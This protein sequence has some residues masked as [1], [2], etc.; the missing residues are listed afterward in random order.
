[1][2]MDAIVA[3]VS[4]ISEDAYFSLP[5]LAAVDEIENFLPAPKFSQNQSQVSEPME[6]TPKLEAKFNRLAQSKALNELSLTGNVEFEKLTAY[7]RQLKNPRTGE[8]V[9][10]EYEQRML[11]RDLVQALAKYVNWHR[12]HTANNSR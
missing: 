6:W 7:R 8:E 3:T 9:I 10:A 12:H 1:L 5:N 2:G 4:T 11:T